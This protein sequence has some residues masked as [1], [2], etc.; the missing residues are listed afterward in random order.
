M[1][2]SRLLLAFLVNQ[3]DIH[4]F[5]GNSCRDLALC[6]SRSLL[7]LQGLRWAVRTSVAEGLALHLLLSKCP[8][9]TFNHRVDAKCPGEIG[10]WLRKST[11]DWQWRARPS[12]L[13]TGYRNSYVAYANMMFAR[14][15]TQNV[16]QGACRWPTHCCLKWCFV[17]TDIRWLDSTPIWLL[18][19]QP[20]WIKSV[21]GSGFGFQG[22]L[23]L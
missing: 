5:V 18:P 12:L 11:V 8:P 2:Q 20:I 4:F 9:S 3:T 22:L 17:F 7:Q 14:T 6:G 15:Q 16:P 21:E 10:V 13:I 23:F 1:C 19:K